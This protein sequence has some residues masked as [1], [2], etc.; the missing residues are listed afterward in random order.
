MDAL[1]IIK[2]PS[3]SSA[4]NLTGVNRSKPDILARVDGYICPNVI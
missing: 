4:L 3:S 1:I 2:L